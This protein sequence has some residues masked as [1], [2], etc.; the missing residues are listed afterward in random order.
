[1]RQNVRTIA[2]VKFV[3]TT[4]KSWPPHVTL[5]TP[6][7]IATLGAEK[8]ISSAMVLRILDIVR[9]AIKEAE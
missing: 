2:G 6:T 5:A 1:M 7:G 3:V 9:N 4:G 8:D